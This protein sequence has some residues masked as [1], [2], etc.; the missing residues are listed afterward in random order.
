M[1]RQQPDSVSFLALSSSNREDDNDDN[2]KSKRYVKVDKNYP[3]TKY[4]AVGVLGSL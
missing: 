3:K 4:E 2:D 1:H